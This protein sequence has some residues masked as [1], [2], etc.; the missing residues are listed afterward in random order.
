M[1]DFL[2][3][4]LNIIYG[5]DDDNKKPVEFNRETEKKEEKKLKLSPPR[6]TYVNELNAMFGQDP[7]IEIEFDDN[8]ENTPE[9]KLKISNQRKYE[10]LTQLLPDEKEFGNVKMKIT[11]IPANLKMTNDQLMRA[12]FEGNPAF[13][14][15]ITVS[16]VYDNPL[17][18]VMFEK[19]AVQY[20]NDNMSD[21]HG[22]ETTLYQDIAERLFRPIDGVMY[23]TESDVKEG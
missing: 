16:G 15:V 6:V 9:V 11:L 20:W 18:Y 8:T 10:A 1:N 14:Q 3:E 22:M 21:P 7:E 13:S 19:K 5:F 4:V 23:S 17:T 12:A 2:T